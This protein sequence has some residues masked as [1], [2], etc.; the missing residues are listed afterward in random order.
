[1]KDV[2]DFFIDYEIKN[3]TTKTKDVIKGDLQKVKREFAE[4]SQQLMAKLQGRLTAGEKQIVTYAD[5]TGA[6]FD[7]TSP[8]FSGVLN[9]TTLYSALRLTLEDKTGI[10]LPPTNNGL[11]YII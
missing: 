1:M 5:N 2:I 9:E 11:G 7:E 10:K 4:S 3:D 8:R 6:T